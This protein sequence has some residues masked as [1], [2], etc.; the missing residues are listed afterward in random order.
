MYVVILRIL[1]EAKLH[2][3]LRESPYT[4]LDDSLLSS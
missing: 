3:R 4:Q 1:I 2:A